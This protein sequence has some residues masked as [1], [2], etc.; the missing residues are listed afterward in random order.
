M[1]KLGM[2]RCRFYFQFNLRFELIIVLFHE[3]KLKLV[4]FICVVM[5]KQASFHY[6]KIL[7]SF[8]LLLCN[9]FRFCYRR[10]ESLKRP[11][12]CSF[13][14][15]CRLFVRLKSNNSNLHHSSGAKLEVLRIWREKC[16]W[17]NKSTSTHVKTGLEYII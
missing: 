3:I 4:V 16:T 7:K 6:S 2:N 1:Q 14:G 15:L 17:S 12:F 8:W 13:P 10:K 11:I 9:I 5:F